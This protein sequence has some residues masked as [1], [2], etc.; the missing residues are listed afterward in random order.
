MSSYN[1]LWNRETQVLWLIRVGALPLNHDPSKRIFRTL[2]KSFA[3]SRVIFGYTCATPFYPSSWNNKFPFL[4]IF[5]FCKGNLSLMLPTCSSSMLLHCAKTLFFYFPWCLNYHSGTQ[6]VW[7]VGI[8]YP[9]HS[10][11]TFLD[12]IKSRLQIL[13]EVLSENWISTYSTKQGIEGSC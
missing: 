1:R 7:N 6:K 10:L 2:L 4:W 3:C 13:L 8:A 9:R 12:A 5:P 11:N